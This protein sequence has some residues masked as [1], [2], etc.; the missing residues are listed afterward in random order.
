MTLDDFFAH[1][2]RDYIAI[3]PAAKT[4]HD[5]VLERESR[6]VN[7]HVAFRTYDMA[8]MNLAALEPHILALGYRM[9]A[10]YEFKDKKLRAFG[11]VHDRED[12]PRVFL[13]ELETA[14]LSDFAQ[15]TIRGLV[16]QVD[17]AAVAK[18]EF[19]WSGRPWK[20]VA[21]AVYDQLAEESEY[22][23]WMA[24]HGMHA[25]H[26]TI[27]VNH[28]E[29]MESL[30]ELLDFVASKGFRLNESGGRVKGSPAVLLEQGSSL[31]DTVDYEFGCGAKA[32]VPTCYYEFARR[33]TDPSTGR[34][35]DGFVAASADKIFE[36]TNRA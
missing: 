30:E 12:A 5:H 28:L 27:S 19:L 4:L 17:P 10:P 15:E 9:L 24:L 34:L 36:S 11:Y 25:N 26:F 13:S 23:A 21:K 29:S 6:I 22:A 33:Y 18:P 7:D 2:W 3:A 1:L 31:A 35:Y 8:P 20:P 14:K 32:K 16:A